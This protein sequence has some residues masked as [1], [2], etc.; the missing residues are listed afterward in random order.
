MSKKRSL[1]ILFVTPECAPWAK[2]GGLGEVSAG[3]PAA[4]RGLGVDARVLMPAYPSVLEQAEGLRRA[5]VFEPEAGFP[6]ATLR[7]GRLPDGVPVMVLDCPELYVRNGGPYQDE[8]SEDHADNALRFGLLSRVAARLSSAASPLSWRPDV[9]HCNDWPAALAPA[10]LK[11]GL[12]D[13]APSLIAVHNLAFQGIFPLDCAS[14]LGLPPEALGVEGVE[15]W[16]RLS[17]LKAGLYYADRIVTVSPTYAREILDEPLGCGMQGLLQAR[18]DRLSGIL[19]GIDTHLWNPATDPHL[20]RNY[21]RDTLPAKL[22]N[23]RALQH[24][25]GLAVDDEVLLLGMTTRLTGQKGVDLVLEALPE[26]L[27]RPLQLVL[28]GTGDAQLEDALR[29]AARRWP[30]RV[31]VRIGFDEALARRIEAGADAFLMPS[32]FEP[33]GLN[34]MYSQCYGTP[35]VV[36]STG[37]L[38]DSVCDYS[39]DALEDGHANGFVFDE[40]DAQSLIATVDRVA[41]VR[42][43]AEAWERLQRNGMRCDFSWSAS[44]ARYLA[45]YRSM[46][47]ADPGAATVPLQRGKVEATQT[48]ASRRRE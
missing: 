41:A 43:D 22:D 1:Q 16:G 31:A 36:R 5:A 7:R 11:L 44:A 19:N 32:R 28:L 45:L 15:Y 8:H 2:T 33:C 3:L 9:V 25:M 40:P 48:R 17:F 37:G 12:P 38:A 42:A 30:G 24:E 18:R 4:L 6:A 47:D 35:P 34:Q 23:K 27:V 26:L 14:A 10:Y 46:V 29:D 13:P 20:V 21:G 39:P